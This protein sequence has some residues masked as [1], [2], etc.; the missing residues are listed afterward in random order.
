M[1]QEGLA[2]LAWGTSF[3]VS[4]Y[5]S[6]RPG[7]PKNTAQTGDPAPPPPFTMSSMQ[8]M[9]FA[10]RA[11]IEA[12]FEENHPLWGGP[13]TPEQYRDYWFSLFLTPWGASNLRYM[14]LTEEEDGPLLSSLKLYRFTGRLFGE[15][16]VIAGIGAVYTP[17]AQR[18][19]GSASLLVSE[20][21]D[22]M[23]K[24]KAA[25]GLLHTEIGLPFY[26]RLGFVPLPAHETL[27]TL[28][29]AEPRPEPGP[30]I[31]I[32]DAA[33]QDAKALA[34]FQAR[35]DEG[36]PLAIERDPVYW[37]FLLYRRR[38]WWERAPPSSA[39]ALSLVARRG[40]EVIAT[41]FAIVSPEE[42]RLQECACLPGAESALGSILDRIWNAG[43]KAGA[44]SWSSRL[45]PGAP[46]DTR[47][48]GT[49]RPADDSL[50]MV[51][52]LGSTPPLAALAGHPR[53]F[54]RDL[55]RF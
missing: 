42:V 40:D 5:A 37:E 30:G 12:I 52:P 54:L 39:H 20:V 3:P 23:Q 35:V 14:A 48:T 7:A 24:K 19:F 26:E 28:D 27:G 8:V 47:L 11:H 36:F 53:Q 22:Y 46:P 4:L 41:G 17:K 25:L 33:L 43:R 44:V 51:A 9:R 45:P 2:G 38:L 10:T 21:L 18:T 1:P 31:E 13:L 15:P 49:I 55:D 16:V 29:A 32:R 50:P 6:Q 34:A